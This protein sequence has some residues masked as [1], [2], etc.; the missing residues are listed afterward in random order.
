MKSLTTSLLLDS[1]PSGSLGTTMRSASILVLSLGL[2]GL[3]SG[4][5][6]AGHGV[7]HR[8]DID[9][10]RAR[11]AAAPDDPA[12]QAALAEAELLLE[13]GDPEVQR[14][15]I[16]RALSLAPDDLRLHFLSAVEHDTHG[17]LAAALDEHLAVITTAASLDDPFARALAEVSMA[18]IADY[19]DSVPGYVARVRAALEPVAD[20]PGGLGIAAFHAANTLLVELAHRRGDL[21]E[22]HART[23]RMGCV[24]HARLAGPFGPRSLLGFDRELPPDAAGPL[25]DHYDLGPGRGDRATREIEGRGCVLSLGGGPVSGPGSSFLEAEVTVPTTGPYVVRLETPNTARL[26][27][28]DAEVAL[29]DR[30]EEPMPRATFHTVRLEAGTHR[31]GLEIATRHPNPV[32]M[33]SILPL[34]NDPSERVDPEAGPLAQY[35]ATTKEIA[36]G[37]WVA[38][39]EVLGSAANGE[40]AAV[41][42]L[43][44]ASAIAL[45]DPVLGTTLGPDEVR[46]LSGA[47]L[48]RDPRAWYAAFARATLEYQGGRVPE[49]IALLRVGIERFPEV[50]V[51]P[52]TLVEA[53]RSQG[54]EEMADAVLADAHTA[55]PHSCRV[56]RAILDASVRRGRASEARELAETLVGCDA[57]SDARYQQLLRQRHWDEASAEL[58]RL[59]ALEPRSA[60]FVVA[61]AELGL[62]RATGDAARALT[63]LSEIAELQPL[64]DAV[65]LMRADRLLAGGDRAGARALLESSLLGEPAAMIELRRIRRSVFGAGDLDAHR[66]D[67]ADVIRRFEASGHSYDAPRVLVLDYTVTR[68]YPD[69]STLELTHNILREQSDEA[70]EEDSQFS[71]PEGAELL[72]LRTINADG[73]RLE[74][75]AIAGLEHI[76]M[77]SVEVGDYVEFEYLRA[78]PPTDAYEGGA[79]GPR[80]Y[81]QNFETPFDWSTLTLIAP[82]DVNIV[83]DPR[84]P[85]PTTETREE[86]GLRVYQWQVHESRPGVP[87]PGAVSAREVFPSVA[88]G[89]RATWAQYIETI[90]DMLLDRDVHDP[91]A[92]RL[93]TEIIGTDRASAEQK[94]ERLY[95]W[96][97]ANVEETGDLFGQGATMALT[98]TGS[99]S[100]VLVYLLHLAGIDASLAMVREFDDDETVGLLPDDE[101]YGTLL[102]RA[103]GTD[104]ERWMSTAERGAAFGVL[105]PLTRGMDAILLGGEDA[106]SEVRVTMPEAEAEAR[107]VEVEVWLEMGGGARFDV[108]ETFRG[109]DAAVWRQQLENVPAAELE[110]VFDQAYVSRLLPGA[111][112]TSLRITGRED[113]EMDV[114]LHYEF[115]VDE[116]GREVRDVRLLPALFPTLLTPSYARLPER[117]MTQVIGDDLAIDATVRLHTPSGTTLGTLPD[118]ERIEGPEGALAIWAIRAIDGGAIIE[119]SVRVPRMRVTPAAYPE[120]ARFCRAVDEVESFEVRVEM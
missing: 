68:L 85:A 72:T 9:V 22:V 28:D 26:S 37:D 55:H 44:L 69:G 109:A 50:V 100:R 46:R 111:H 89:T 60:R 94:M 49:S 29:V 48:A 12:A 103:R 57:R 117:H 6:G 40:E 32:A 92:A 25:T 82:R 116:L 66:L 54:F 14:A 101:T 102:V 91:L 62:A 97:V 104:G 86:D 67:G 119:R 76:E 2:F 51:F 105:P 39:R 23:E 77:P 81:F 90:R 41:P 3:T 93:V 99:R 63:L 18:T 84:G 118:E 110:D 95:H 83:V 4:C 31:L 106:G 79:V 56:T 34:G 107:T 38:A 88:W 80:F 98:R 16:D 53:L 71:P 11:A 1:S 61:D 8:D 52:S 64:S 108:T 43:V 87:E 36:R 47:A 96:V 35:L 15:A 21:D 13:G 19:D 78:T 59:A 58:T 27:F 45:N 20:A 30:R 42:F 5:G 114:T 74:P 33:I 73:T 120:L 65:A 24:T 7:G 10:I 115:E 112:T 17:E 75:D 70:A 113:P